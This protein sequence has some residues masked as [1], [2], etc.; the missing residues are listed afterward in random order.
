MRWQRARC[1]KVIVVVLT[2]LVEQ[3]IGQGLPTGSPEEVGMSTERLERVRPMLEQYVNEGT[4]PGIA[5]MVA[6]RGKVIYFEVFGKA[7]VDPSV[8]MD[9]S[10]IFRIYSMTKPVVSVAAMMLFE[11]GLFRL[12]DP[13]AVYLPELAGLRL[14]VEGRGDSMVTAE[15]EQQM[16]I[17]QLLTH[18]SGLA[19][20]LQGESYVDSLYREVDILD[21]GD[22][23]DETIGKLAALPLLNQPGTI[24]K[25]GVSVDVVAALV[26]RLAGVPIEE[27]LQERIFEPLR[28]MDT[29]YYVRAEDQHR[30]AGC[31]EL[32][33]DNSWVHS[34]LFWADEYETEPI[35]H[36]GGFGLASTMP[37]YMRFSQ[38]LLNG[39]Q[40]DGERLLS[41]KTVALMLSDHLPDGMEAFSN[42]GFAFGFSI[43]KDNVRA[44]RLASTGTVGWL[45][46]A[47]TFFGI[48][49]EDDLIWMVWAQAFPC[50]QWKLSNDF[51]TLVHQAVVDR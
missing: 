51:E 18:T 37:D 31:Y 45:G 48:D 9:E 33:S 34:Q 16:T 28:M 10:T 19:N 14:Y 22:S 36:A 41:P 20:G 39:G 4:F 1:T 11:E 32:D 21:R 13:V 8:D 46:V 40:L 29:G 2:M 25:Y 17:R 49:R 30:L 50:C 24:W 47:N 27:F 23:L 6:R 15:V 26:E 7:R 44:G 12:D 35:L 5:A 3:S 38:M 42:H 43:L